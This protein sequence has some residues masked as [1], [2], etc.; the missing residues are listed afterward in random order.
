M[1]AL[2]LIASGKGFLISPIFRLARTAQ[3]VATM[4][5]HH[6]KLEA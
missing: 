5:R 4:P 6:F 3:R 1:S 2:H